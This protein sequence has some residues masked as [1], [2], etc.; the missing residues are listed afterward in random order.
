MAV[1]SVTFGCTD[2][3]AGFGA[4]QRGDE[5]ADARRHVPPALPAAGVFPGQHAARGP[6]LGVVA[7]AFADLPGH[8]AQ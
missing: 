8:G 6:G 2:I 1:A 5:I 7:E 4:D 3:L